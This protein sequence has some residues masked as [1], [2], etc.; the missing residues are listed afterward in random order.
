LHRL[1]DIRSTTQVYIDFDVG[2]NSIRVRSNSAAKNQN[3]I[4]EVKKAI[5]CAK[6]DAAGLAPLFLVEPPSLASIRS[7]V[8]PIFKENGYDPQHP[9]IQKVILSGSKLSAKDTIAWD[10]ERLKLGKTNKSLFLEHL[11]R[12]FEEFGDLQSNMR[13]RVH[14][15]HVELLL[16]RKDF[17]DKSYS[18]QKFMKMMLETRTKAQLEKK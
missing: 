14:F 9:V 11:K 3:A 7:T 15:G 4:E 16:Y 5:R 8:I 6:A 2:C 10:E 13:M 12:S 17:K 18:V 1:N